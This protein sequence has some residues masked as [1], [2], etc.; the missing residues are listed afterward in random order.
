M[1]LNPATVSCLQVQF[2]KSVSLFF[3][4]RLQNMHETF[5]ASHSCTLYLYAANVAAFTLLNKVL[6]DEECDATEAQ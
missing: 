2:F 4:A 6:N 5:V 1:K 3:G